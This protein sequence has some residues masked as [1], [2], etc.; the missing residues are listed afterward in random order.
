MA[1]FSWPRPPNLDGLSTNE[2]VSATKNYVN[3]VRVHMD[4]LRLDSSQYGAL[5]GFMLSALTDATK[6]FEVVY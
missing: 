5:I 2:A 1:S 6:I 4:N 3:D